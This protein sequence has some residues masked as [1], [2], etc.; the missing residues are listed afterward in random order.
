MLSVTSAPK[1]PA[2][3]AAGS[4]QSPVDSLFAGIMVQMGEA[5]AKSGVAG[6]SDGAKLLAGG[7]EGLTAD[8]TEAPTPAVGDPQAAKDAA[9]EAAVTMPGAEDGATAAPGAEEAPALPPSTPATTIIAESLQTPPNGKEGAKTP[10]TTEEAGGDDDA[11][12]VTSGDNILPAG[13]APV[14]AALGANAASPST[15]ITPETGPESGIAAATLGSAAGLANGTRAPAT[16]KLRSSA[17]G[18]ADDATQQPAATEAPGATAGARLQPADGGARAIN[19]MEGAQ[20]G[21]DGQHMTGDDATLLSEGS[22]ARTA[23]AALSADDRLSLMPAANNDRPAGTSPAPLPA[24]PPAGETGIAARDAAETAWAEQAAKGLMA[25]LDG[26]ATQARFRL[27]PEALGTVDISVSFD[28]GTPK[29]SFAVGNDAARAAIDSALPR[30]G[31]MLERNLAENGAANAETSS[32][33]SS[34]RQEQQ[35]DQ[36]PSHARRWEAQPDEAERRISTS[37]SKNE[38]GGRLRLFA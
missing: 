29:V 36:Q 24:L 6:L 19:A 12:D 25:K 38:E 10:A 26:G 8:G 22:L 14:G 17:A 27:T 28:T 13:Q 20:A 33:Q 34:A 9:L 37:D 35:P 30:L 5:S 3:P 18:L 32:R 7:A 11:L 4:P 16:Q 1:A 2:N 31:D 15:D 21:I 23:N